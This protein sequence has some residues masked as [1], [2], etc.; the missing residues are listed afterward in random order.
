MVGMV[1]IIIYLEAMATILLMAVL[2]MTPFTVELE[3]TSTL[4]ATVMITSMTLVGITIST[5]V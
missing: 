5:P 2:E 4:E 3:M 1:M